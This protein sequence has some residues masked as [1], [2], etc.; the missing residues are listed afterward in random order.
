MARFFIL[1]RLCIASPVRPDNYRDS[2]QYSPRKMD[3]L[4]TISA[5]HRKLLDY[6]TNVIGLNS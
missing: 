4:H 5:L 1:Y 3:Y 2:G 6:L